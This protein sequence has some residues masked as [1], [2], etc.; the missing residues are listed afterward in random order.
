MT[1]QEMTDRYRSGESLRDIAAVANATHAAVRKRLLRAG[2]K[3]RA[4]G[5]QSPGATVAIEPAP[6]KRTKKRPHRPQDPPPAPQPR[7]PRTGRMR[8]KV[9]RRGYV[10]GEMGLWLTKKQIARGELTVE[11][12]VSY[13]YL[14][15]KLA[16]EI[17]G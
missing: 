5:F 12:A 16:Q 15:P 7:D 17:Y 3:M 9:R 8:T 11:E 13:G 14:T 2:V 6:K 1:T 10:G 4:S